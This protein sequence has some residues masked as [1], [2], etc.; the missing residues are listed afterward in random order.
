M[1]T[2][3]KELFTLIEKGPRGAETWDPGMVL[4]QPLA[5]TDCHARNAGHGLRWTSVMLIVIPALTLGRGGSM[6][7]GEGDHP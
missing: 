6:R 4:P 3:A 1:E 2:P 5:L 7:T